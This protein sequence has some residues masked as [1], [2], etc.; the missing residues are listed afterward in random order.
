MFSTVNRLESLPTLVQEEIIVQL[1]TEP[2]HR[3]L[4][5][6]YPSMRSLFKRYETK[7]L[8]RIL[9]NLI[10]DDEEGNIR[11][12]IWTITN[13]PEARRRGLS[14]PTARLITCRRSGASKSWPTSL[15]CLRSVHRLISR[16]ITFIEDLLSKATSKYPPRAYL[17]LP[18]LKWGTRCR[19]KGRRLDTKLLSFTSLTRPERYRLLRAFVRYELVCLI[20]RLV[21]P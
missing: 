1:G 18:D 7:I 11:R 19:F 5:R 12:D 10:T 9:Q 17:G 21:K 3:S 8:H 15:S 2:S 14:D 13:T 4:F 20:Y 16:V 6:A